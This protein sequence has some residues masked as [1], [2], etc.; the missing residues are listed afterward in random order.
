MK[1][2]RIESSN[3]LKA[4]RKS[5]K[6]FLIATGRDAFGRKSRSISQWIVKGEVDQFIIGNYNARGYRY[7]DDEIT[8]SIIAGDVSAT[9]DEF[10]EQVIGG[11]D[12]DRSNLEQELED[13]TIELDITRAKAQSLLIDIKVEYE[14]GITTGSDIEFYNRLC[15]KGERLSENKERITRKLNKYDIIQEESSDVDSPFIGDASLVLTDKQEEKKGKEYNTIHWNECWKRGELS[16][17]IVLDKVYRERDPRKLYAL[18][19]RIN[20]A[21]YGRTKEQVGNMPYY[22]FIKCK[23]AI[24]SRIAILVPTKRNI[25][26]ALKY[27]KDAK[28][29]ENRPNKDPYTETVEFTYNPDL[30][31]SGRFGLNEDAMIALIDKSTVAKQLRLKG[32]DFFEYEEEVDSD[33]KHIDIVALYEECRGNVSKM[34]RRLGKSRYL[35]KKQLVQAIE[36]ALLWQ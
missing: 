15:D 5:M 20:K 18:S 22:W 1:D 19:S 16:L 4:I 3:L 27:R 36:E 34:S 11:L 7:S 21:R 17:T 9:L 28:R 10:F 24:Q 26:S 31:L 8:S 32:R 12:R 30:A 6:E 23:A 35:A 13:T 29:I 14:L 2:V 33:Q 25:E